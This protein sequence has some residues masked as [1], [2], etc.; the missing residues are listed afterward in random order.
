[1]KLKRNVLE[2]LG[3]AVKGDPVV[4]EGLQ[5]LSYT[6][7]YLFFRSVG[8][9][10]SRERALSTRRYHS[11]VLHHAF[12]DGAYLE[13]SDNPDVHKM[14]QHLQLVENSQ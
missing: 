2:I 3:R 5:L 1:M 10:R 12:L 13:L 14:I 7:V 4:K 6:Q 11:A 8:Q 9:I